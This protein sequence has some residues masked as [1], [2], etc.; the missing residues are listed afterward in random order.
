LAATKI[1]LCFIGSEI[2]SRY[3]GVGYVRII[4]QEPVAGVGKNVASNKI[5]APL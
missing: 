5:R 4:D 2:G 3:F 1:A